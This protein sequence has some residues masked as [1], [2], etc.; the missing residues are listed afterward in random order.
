MLKI[1]KGKA[2]RWEMY[3]ASVK[4]YLEAYFRRVP[5]LLDITA[6]AVGGLVRTERKLDQLELELIPDLKD[7]VMA[8]ITEYTE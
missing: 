6:R 2:G 3:A 8:Y 7:K 5:T 1:T 4:E